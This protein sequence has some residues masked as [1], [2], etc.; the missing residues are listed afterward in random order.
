MAFK[1]VLVLHGPN[2]NLLGERPGDDRAIT[3]DGLNHRLQQRADALGLTLRIFQSNHEGELIDR[4]HAERQWADAVVISP[5]ALAH[6]SYVLREALVA[7]G[8]PAIEVHLS[9]IRRRESW[10]RKSVIKDAC[11]AQVLG[12]GVG[13]YLLALERFGTD[14][15]AGKKRG[16]TRAPGKTVGRPAVRNSVANSDRNPGAAELSAARGAE[17]TLGRSVGVAESGALRGSEKTL[18][19]SAGAAE[20]GALRGSEKALGRSAGSAESSA[21]RSSE[22]TLGR[23]AG[24]AESGAGRG[25]AKTV[26]RAESSRTV[27]SD[28]LTR[29]LVR[30]KL[31][32]RLS[33]KLTAGGLAAWARAQWNKV[34]E[35]G[36]AEVDHRDELE[37]V[38]QTLT[39][40]T[41]AASRLSDEQLVDL[42]AQLDR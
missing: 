23:S 3:L 20:S 29:A 11:E 37:D 35:G 31:S 6:T 14:A 24:V 28:F 7:V 22:K 39:L 27:S 8:K 9:D 34:Q 19:R 5:D 13:S 17:K 12:K 1:N 15:P 33:G 25:S 10:R 40:S 30:Q 36:P 16:G 38:L 2:L 18:G 26:G 4:L 42:M 21:G 41:M 32:E